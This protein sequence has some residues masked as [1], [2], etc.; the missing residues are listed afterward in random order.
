MTKQRMRVF[1][2]PALIA[3][4]LL[5]GA[6][7]GAEDAERHFETINGNEMTLQKWFDQVSPGEKA[8]CRL[9]DSLAFPGFAV[10]DVFDGDTGYDLVI[11]LC[12]KTLTLGEPLV[13][14]S[15]D[16]ALYFGYGNKIVIQNGTILAGADAAA[17]IRSKSDLTLTDV[18]VGNGERTYSESVIVAPAGKLTVN[19]NTAILQGSA[20]TV[21]PVALIVGEEST[22]GGADV[23]IDTTGEVNGRL[24]V[25]PLSKS[26]TPSSLTVRNIK[27]TVKPLSAGLVGGISSSN[28]FSSESIASRINVSGGTWKRQTSPSC[29]YSTF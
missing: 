11:D 3:A 24:K 9:G 27:S 21:N 7:A 29:S 23:T 14:P 18:Q 22:T 10:G 1:F 20:S 12:G 8:G 19:G 4:M 13:G 5:F 2:L 28:S 16:D 15:L 25:L 6:S 17:V 26:M